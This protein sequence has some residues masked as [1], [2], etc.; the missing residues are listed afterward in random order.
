MNTILDAREAKTVFKENWPGKD[1]MQAFFK[2]HPE[3]AERMGQALG[4][5]RAV[6]TKESLAERFQQ[7]KQNL[8]AMDPTLLTSP[9][10]IFNAGE[11]S[12]SVLSKYKKQKTNKQTKNQ[13]D[14]SQ[15][16]L[17]HQKQHTAAG[18]SVGQFLCCSAVYST[19][20]TT[21]DLHLHQRPS[22]QC[23]GGV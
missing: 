14:K 13:Q 23:A 12:F 2:R 8:D 16:C 11:S 6:M 20:A 9:G 7:M 21:A 4:Q 17:L 3:V 22:L 15:A 10:R 5:E 1:W 19:T 18:D